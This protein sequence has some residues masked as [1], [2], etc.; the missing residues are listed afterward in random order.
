M[1]A[2][3]IVEKKEASERERDIA[4]FL[5]IDNDKREYTKILH[6]CTYSLYTIHPTDIYSMHN[7][8]A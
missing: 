5:K 4:S 6:T 7:N 1:F 8:D 3:Y 2:A